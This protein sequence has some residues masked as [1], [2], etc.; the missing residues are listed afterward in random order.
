M[1]HAL[2]NAWVWLRAVTRSVT[3][4]TLSGTLVVRVSRLGWERNGVNVNYSRQGGNRGQ[5]SF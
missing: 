1:L 3:V 5:R 4:P 2:L